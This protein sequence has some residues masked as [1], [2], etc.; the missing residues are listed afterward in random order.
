MI[1]NAQLRDAVERAIERDP[2]LSL[3]EIARRAQP[4]LASATTVARLLGRIK[5]SAYRRNG[6]DYP[7][8]FRTEI[9]VEQA[10]RIV[11][12]SG[13]DPIEIDGL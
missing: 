2:R 3:S 12:A 7:A 9:D 4:P 5:T 10:A 1:P 11:H 13:I 8:R 6:R